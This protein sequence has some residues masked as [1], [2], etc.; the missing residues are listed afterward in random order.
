M[1]PKIC[2][3]TAIYGKYESS[4]KRFKTQTVP[5]DFICFTDNPNTVANGWILDTTPYHKTNKSGI[6]PGIYLNSLNNNEHTFN[7]SK[8]YKQA[9]QNI[10]R[11]KK[12]DVIVWLDGT[13]ELIHDKISEYVL[14]N[15]YDRKIIG[16]HHEKRFG[17]LKDEVIASRF[18]KYNDT[19]WNYQLQPRQD[20][21]KQYEEYLKDGYS[22]EYFSKIKSHTPHLGVWITCF[23]AF[24]NTD[25]DV[26]AFLDKWYLQTLQYSTQDQVGF[27]YVCQK[28]NM[29]P[30]TLPNNEIKGELAHSHTDFYIKHSH[31]N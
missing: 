7:I 11:L 16:W 19:I 21:D 1:T 20:I 26:S 10:P 8:Y 25:T 9:F 24:L 18:S 22:E 23:V 3:I 31:G 4:C 27:P 12:Y 17:K 6:D 14:K 13:I 2:F 29:I 5:T 28:M 15:I 30:F